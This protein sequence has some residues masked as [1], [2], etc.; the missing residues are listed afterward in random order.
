[1][2]D[3]PIAVAAGKLVGGIAFVV[4]GLW[5]IAANRRLSRAVAAGQRAVLRELVGE[6]RSAFL[7]RRAVSAGI[8]LFARVVAGWIAIGFVG[9]GVIMVVN[10]TK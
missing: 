6:R 9:L 5:S 1:M 2:S 4:A 10:A 7:A 8:V 3:I